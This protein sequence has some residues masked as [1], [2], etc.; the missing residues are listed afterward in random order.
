[1]QARTG[2]ARLFAPYGQAQ[3]PARTGVESLMWE[4]VPETRVHP[5]GQALPLRARV[6]KGHPDHVDARY[7]LFE[8]GRGG[9]WQRIVLTEQGRGVHE[10]LIDTTADAIAVYFE[11]EDART[12]LERI[13]LVPPPA[14]DRATLATTPPAYAAPWYQTL[15]V[16][17]GP[18]LDERALTDTPSLVGSL[19]TLTLELNKPLPLPVD[20]RTLRAVLGWASGALP[21]ISSDTQRPHVWTLEWAIEET[22]T[23]RLQLADEYG[24]TNTEPITYTIEAVEDLPP[25]V[26]I[27]EPPSDEVVLPTAVVPLVV[28]A[29]DD[30]A[31]DRLAIEAG[32]QVDGAEGEPEHLW[33]ETQPAS[34][35]ASTLT[36]ELDLGRHELVEGDVVLVHGVAADVFELHGERHPEVRSPPR[37]LSIISEREFSRRIR[38]ELGV[39][40]QNVIRIEALQTE[41]QDDVIDDGAAPGTERA[42]AKIGER[43][44]DQRQAVDEIARRMDD[45]RL[46]DDALGEL[47]SQVG[48]LL[49]F[50]GRS[51]NRAV[52]AIETRQAGG[53][54]AG[55][56]GP[57]ERER[58]AEE[59]ADRTR[60]ED[61]DDLPEIREPD[62]A[63]RPIVEAQQEVRN[64]LADLIELLDRDEDS[65]VATRWL[66]DLAE[67]QRRLE[68]EA[69][70]LGRQTI[71]R[72]VEE[73]TA[74]EQGQL[75]R[76]AERQEDLAEQSRQLMEDL[77][78]RAE[79]LEQ[80]D[81]TAADAMRSA[82]QTGEEQELDRQMDRAAERM[83]QNQM[84]TARASQQA[85]G[86]TIQQMLQQM[87]ESRKSNAQELLR[88]LL[89]LEESIERLVMVQTNEIALLDVARESN[90]YT[91]RDRPMI[92]LAQNTQAVASDART[93]GQEVRRVARELDRAA[94]AQ[95]AAVEAF[96]AKPPDGE[97]ADTAERRSLE[98]LE[99]ALALTRQLAAAVEAR[100]VLRERLDLVKSYREFLEQ[101]MAVRTRTLEL[102]PRQP[103]DRRGLV[104]ARGL[105]REQEG[106]GTGLSDMRTATAELRE[107]LVFR[108]VHELID[109]WSQA[110][111]EALFEGQVDSAVT[112]RQQRIADSINRLIDALDVVMAEPEEF[113]GQG[114]GAGGAGAGSGDQ[115]LIPPVAELKLMRGMQEQLYDLT[116]DLDSRRD[117]SDAQRDAEARELGEQQRELQELGREL[118]EA[119]QQ[120]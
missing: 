47:T 102:A 7:R 23:L 27:L 22:R 87:R 21:A 28:E 65:W 119:L 89:S 111:S 85:A 3:W 38:R 4:V 58:R 81:P 88:R 33:S 66:E 63:D 57:D 72:E 97:Q 30:V 104:E 82:A 103:L 14:V 109:G 43:I 56:T 110:A 79:A 60:D 95:G 76:L 35:P 41:L 116:R 117:L 71:G 70:E 118:L 55:A 39:V 16:D 46:D 59:D 96:R 32:R 90:D 73:L 17:L 44:A 31:V 92:R 42:Q 98:Q 62:E 52:E 120:Q 100:E 45:N 67:A 10:R 105:S 83:E 34:N 108:R 49:D 68:A 91:G 94:D 18:G 8:A 78:E 74:A 48:D 13:R 1:V 40:R 24:L 107:S 11:T 53:R 12:T 54:G 6:T 36:T 80:T 114:Q 19:A 101:Q 15:E 26:T 106:I 93:A 25:R 61:E 115:P 5:R 113:E 50:A 64:E 75:R 2:L 69:A 77:R 29:R 99:E 86:Q 112:D 84:R 37:R 20:E 51:A 9:N